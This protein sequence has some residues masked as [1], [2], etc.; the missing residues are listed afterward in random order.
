MPS[1]GSPPMAMVVRTANDDGTSSDRRIMDVT[2]TTTDARIVAEAVAAAAAGARLRVDGDDIPV[3]DLRSGSSHA[4]GAPLVGRDEP[5]Q[6][7]NV[8][9]CLLVGRHGPVRV[10]LVVD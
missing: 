1:P 6:P 2:L 5:G 7:A 3:F 8:K 10:G 9:G 4:D